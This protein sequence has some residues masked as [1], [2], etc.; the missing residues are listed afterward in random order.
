MHRAAT[1][2]VS[3][4]AAL[5]AAAQVFTCTSTTGTREFSDRPCESARPAA[6]ALTVADAFVLA[7][8][9]ESPP[10][11]AWSPGAVL[12]GRSWQSTG[13]RSGYWVPAGTAVLLPH[14]HWHRGRR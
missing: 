7:A 14:R 3:A 8:L 11:L 2:I 5:P 1:I 13:R 6:P 12:D 10:R 4:L 9:P